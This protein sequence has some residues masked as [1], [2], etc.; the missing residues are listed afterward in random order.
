MVKAAKIPR[1][2]LR[3]IGGSWRGRR[4]EFPCVEGLRPTPDRVR[5][6][7]FNWLQ[8]DIHG[9]ACL[10]L[11]AGSGALGFEALSR[12]AASALMLEADPQAAQALRANA[13]TLA[14]AECQVIRG[15]A[16]AHLRTAPSRRF[17]LVFMD[18]PFALALWQPLSQALC[19]RDWLAPEALVYVEAPRDCPPVLPTHWRLHKHRQAGQVDFALYR[20]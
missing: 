1:S 10:D 8:P 18:P 20:A 5:E 16:L 19:E 15:D 3:I 13:E 2:S 9:A 11:C 6:T 17:D 7:L 12:G 14:A 4:V